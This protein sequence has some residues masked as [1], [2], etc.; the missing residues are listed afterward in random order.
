MP[1]RRTNV[2]LEFR[3]GDDIYI[4][5]H[6]QEIWNKYIPISDTYETMDV[7]T[8]SA[9]DL[10]VAEVNMRLVQ[11]RPAYKGRTDEESQK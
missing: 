11:N 2:Y 4:R 6:N 10:L 1:L 9:L 3:I 8:C 7:D 5:Y